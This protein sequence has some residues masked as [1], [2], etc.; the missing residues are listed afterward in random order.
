[1]AAPLNPEFQVLYHG[2]GASAAADI[3]ARGVDNDRSSLGYFGAGFYCACEESLARSNYADF[4]DDDEAGAVLEI[5]LTPGARI[6]DLRLESDWIVWRDGD[7]ARQLHQPG[8]WRTMV[9]AGIDELPRA[10]PRLLAGVSAAV[11]S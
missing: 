8:F 7:Y 2:T 4:A 9:A 10:C 11:L 6:L 1:M 5:V 3:L